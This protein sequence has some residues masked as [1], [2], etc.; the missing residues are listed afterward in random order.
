[1][2]S[3]VQKKLELDPTPVKEQISSACRAP[4]TD[5]QE[6]ATPPLKMLCH[7]S[8]Q[9]AGI[10][11]YEKSEIAPTSS[12]SEINLLQ[13]E[14]QFRELVVNWLP[15]SKQF[16]PFDIGDQEWLFKTKQPRRDIYKRHI[17]CYL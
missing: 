3:E 11:T 10:D 14:P 17:Y 9:G 8:S 16:E 6:L 12:C 13:I 7:T 2:D 15:P 4:A 1:M 5:G